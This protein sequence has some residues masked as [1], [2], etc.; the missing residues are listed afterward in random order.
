MDDDDIALFMF[1]KICYVSIL[2]TWEIII[3]QVR[4]HL[5][6]GKKTKNTNK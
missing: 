2:E 1:G 3:L 6:S 4:K 5:N